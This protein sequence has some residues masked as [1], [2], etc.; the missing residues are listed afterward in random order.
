MKNKIHTIEVE[1]NETRSVEKILEKIKEN[2]II[3]V[4][5]KFYEDED[6][7][8]SITE[9][10]PAIIL[11][12]SGSSGKPRQCFH[13]LDNIKLSAATSGQWLIEQGFELQNCL[14]LN[15]LPLNHI[16]GLM[17][18]FRS[19]TWGCDCINISPNLIKKTR[20]LLLFTIKSKKNKNNLIT[21]L[22]PTQLKRLLA[23]K[24]GISW[25]KIFDLIW[26]GGA[27]ISR[28]TAEQCIEEKI[29]LAPCYGST[30]T[31]AMVT[32]LKPKEFLMGFKN[33]GEILPDTKIRINAQGLIEIKSARI[34]IEIKDS[35]K[36]ENF[37][38]KNGWWQTG[39]LGEINQINNSLYLN[40]LGRSDNAFNSGGEIVFP[41][42]IE[43]RL[44]DFIMKENIPINKF[45]ISKVSDKLWG[46]K[47]KII[48]EYKEHTNHKNIENSL[49][50]LKKFSQSWPKHEKP[51]KWIVK[52]NTSAE[53][54]NY[55]FKKE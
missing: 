45:N 21:S 17:P 42:V 7:L 52:K 23:Q 49:N 53:K 25:L 24:D 15:T 30:E 27:S 13:H 34:G 47:I 12:S 40:F 37:K 32:S 41:K 6:V 38:N 31:A 50:L 5:N 29:K 10:G 20:E 9:N 1:N 18:I 16:S 26:V 2:K 11:N 19:Q 22:V 3:Y 54:I 35:S 43:S 46:N 48:V 4:K 14:I 39:D 8:D 36:T 51:E 28:E 55:K 33:V 44:N